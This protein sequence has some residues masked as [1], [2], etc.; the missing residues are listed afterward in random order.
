ML[1]APAR[2]KEVAKVITLTILV[3]SLLQTAYGVIAQPPASYGGGVIH[4]AISVRIAPPWDT[5]DDG[6][7]ECVLNALSLA[8][9]RNEA[10]IVEINSYGGLLEAG[11]AIGDAFASSKV[12][13]IAYV[14]SGNAFSAATLIMLPAN[15]I[16]VSPNA[17]IG[18]M[19][20]VEYNPM[21]GQVTYVNASKIINAVVTKAD[22]YA[23]LRG[24]NVTLVEE[25]VRNAK[26]ITADKAVKWHVAD[27]M[28][29][30][31]NDLLNKLRGRE[32]R[33]SSGNYTLEITEVTP[34]Y[35][36]LRSRTIS[37]FE[38]PIV[39]SIMMTIGV[40][41][42]LFALLSGKLPVLPL[43]LLFLLLGI[44]GSGF[45]P[46]LMALAF[47]TLG[48]ILLFV[49]LFV[50]PGFGILGVSGITLIALGIAL[51]PVTIPVG[52]SPPPGYVSNLRVIALTIGGFL[53]A[54]TGFVL[55]K[56]IEAKR[57]KPKPFTPVG[58]VGVAIDEITPESTGFIKVGGEYWKAVSDEVIKPGTKVK[59]LSLEGTHLR[60]KALRE[61]E[62]SY[63]T[64][65]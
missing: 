65:Q 20:P 16:A 62:D 31:T 12:P 30:D 60:V 44:L 15:V 46:N 49:E 40:L 63:P 52:T 19:Q 43:A 41:G 28:A 57:S 10:L 55:Y 22:S 34:Y 42:T 18:D 2:A 13:V 25:F 64:K 54:F 7:K 21:T 37:V 9:S 5:I 29:T 33:T 50:T 47:L 38:N 61:E 45:S 36:S 32:V 14:Y 24:R 17:V 35:C 11:F 8:E 6:V 48:A 27:F 56:I 26:A 51:S 23:K 3:V 59:V 58:V 39:S 53:G 4:S 1:K